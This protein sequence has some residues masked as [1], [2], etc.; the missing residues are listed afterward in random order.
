METKVAFILK[1]LDILFP[2]AKC[3]LNHKNPFELIC[4]VLLSAQT[5]TLTDEAIQY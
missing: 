2:D 1:E 5:Y 3:E 4:A